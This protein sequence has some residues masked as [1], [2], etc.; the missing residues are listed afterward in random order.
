MT[1]WHNLKYDS[2]EKSSIK[3][4]LIRGL[5]PKSFPWTIRDLS[6]C[7]ADNDIWHIKI[8]CVNIETY[9]FSQKVKA[10]L[11]YEAHCK[12]S[13]PNLEKMDMEHER[14]F[15]L[16]LNNWNDLKENL[17]LNFNVTLEKLDEKCVEVCKL[18]F[19]KIQVKYTL[20]KKHELVNDN[21][22]RC[23]ISNF[24]L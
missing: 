17:S 2:L 4:D 13:I 15:Q 5:P 18:F 10:Y 11:S 7:D 1:F 3:G 24:S 8:L 23:R 16:G 20:E 9:E 21:I 22:K 14:L 19:K 12:I 6:Y